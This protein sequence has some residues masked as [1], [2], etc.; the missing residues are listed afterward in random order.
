MSRN[1]S[2]Y[3]TDIQDACKKV[4]KF[5]K[6]MTYKDFVHDDLHFDAV[7]RNL[8]IIGEAVKNISEE[9]RRKYPEV[10][11]R[12]IAGFRDIVAHE[13]FG[14]ND[15]TVWDIVVNEIP[16]LLAIAKK[17]LGKK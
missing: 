12:K 14:V 11:W 4:L 6:G 2:L 5:T 7:L 1:E 9:T 3:L 10:K 13:Y 17:M 8:E 15:E 16:A